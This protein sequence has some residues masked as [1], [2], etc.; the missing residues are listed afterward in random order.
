MASRLAHGIHGLARSRAAKAV[1]DYRS[2]RG[3][4]DFSAAS[5]SLKLMAVGQPWTPWP[6]ARANA[7]ARQ[8]TVQTAGRETEV[9][10]HTSPM[11]SVGLSCRTLA[12]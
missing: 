9:P 3:S 10:C 1:D 7:R 12:T 5:E 6:S 8:S 4:R 2:P 11:E